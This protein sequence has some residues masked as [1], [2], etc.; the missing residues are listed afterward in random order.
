MAWRPDT[1]EPART[2]AGLLSPTFVTG[3]LASSVQLR[4]R[5]GPSVLAGD[6]SKLAFETRRVLRAGADYV[7][8]DMFDGNWIPGAF[9][10]GPIVVKALR[11]HEPQAYFDVHLCVTRPEQYLEDMARAGAS[12]VTLHFEALADPAAAAERAH[13][14]GLEAGLALAPQTSAEATAVLAAAENFDVVL[15]MTVP[16]GFGGQA[17]MPEM[18]PKLRRLREA[19][20]GKALEVDGGVTPVTAALASAAGANEAVAGSSVFRSRN[21]RRAIRHQGK[22]T[23]GRI[24]L[25]LGLQVSK[26]WQQDPKPSCLGEHSILTLQGTTPW[27][28]ARPANPATELTSLQKTPCLLCFFRLATFR[29]SEMPLLVWLVAVRARSTGTGEAPPAVAAIS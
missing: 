28:G 3:H 8:L 16:P 20:P 25:G 11:A 27:S 9:T 10:F 13:G 21:M 24:Q 6:L 5:V 4:V 12:R 15:V 2:N 19:F 1:A 14:L 29:D 7:H 18:L 17:F 22:L 23:D 26:Y